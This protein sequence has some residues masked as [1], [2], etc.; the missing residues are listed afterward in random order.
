MFLI[1]LEPLG[2]GRMSRRPVPTLILRPPSSRSMP[3]SGYRKPLS[4]VAFWWYDLLHLAAAMIFLMQAARGPWKQSAE[5]LFA[6]EGVN[7]AVVKTC[8]WAF[9]EVKTGVLVGQ[10]RPSICM[11]SVPLSSSAVK[12]NLLHNRSEPLLTALAHISLLSSHGGLHRM[13]TS[14]KCTAL[15]QPYFQQISHSWVFH[16]CVEQTKLQIS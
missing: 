15:R 5:E 9:W 13:S 16:F 8:T 2:P 11:A 1:V 4:L 6:D 12:S 3:R 10:C 7:S 14:R